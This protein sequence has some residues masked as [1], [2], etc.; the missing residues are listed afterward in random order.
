LLLPSASLCASFLEP[1]PGLGKVAVADGVGD[2]AEILP[3]CR[4]KQGLVLGERLAA[5][6]VVVVQLSGQLLAG[7][8][9]LSRRVMSI[10]KGRPWR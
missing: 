9:Y 7:R 6:E 5:D 1:V 3:E 8:A 2:R 10:A 4:A